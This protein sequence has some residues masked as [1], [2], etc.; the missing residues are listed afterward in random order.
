ML[1]LVKQGTLLG[2]LGRHDCGVRER[3]G[4][5]LGLDEMWFTETQGRSQGSKWIIITITEKLPFPILFTRS[6]MVL[7]EGLTLQKVRKSKDLGA[8]LS[9]S[10]GL[11][12]YRRNCG[13]SSKSGR[14]LH[15]GEHGVLPSNLSHRLDHMPHPWCI[16]R[17]AKEAKSRWFPEKGFWA[18][19]GSWGHPE[20]WRTGLGTWQDSRRKICS[21]TRQECLH[22]ALYVSCMSKGDTKKTEKETELERVEEELACSGSTWTEE[23]TKTRVS[24][25]G[26][27]EG[28]SPWLPLPSL[29][30]PYA[31]PYTQLWGTRQAP[32]NTG[33]MLERVQGSLQIGEIAYPPWKRLRWFYRKSGKFLFLHTW[34]CRLCQRASTPREWAQFSSGLGFQSGPSSDDKGLSTLGLVDSPFSSFPH[35][36]RNIV[37]TH[38]G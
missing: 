22:T 27:W 11:W 14:T 21:E 34:V 28:L 3:L 30:S 17:V 8:G 10:N 25:Q 38:H 26:P 15:E 23:Q 32:W 20:G 7:R 29:T 1:N 6:S 5:C 18:L 9:F 31:I 13:V 35:F 16:E 2:G 24:Y 36:G 19:P 12:G 33:A 4:H 37:L